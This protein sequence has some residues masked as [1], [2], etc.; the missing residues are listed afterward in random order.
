MEVASR[1]A[2]ELQEIKMGQEDGKALNQDLKQPFLE[3]PPSLYP[4]LL[5]LENLQLFWLFEDQQPKWIP[6]PP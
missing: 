3:H 1:E 4:H 5:E 6:Q 2:V